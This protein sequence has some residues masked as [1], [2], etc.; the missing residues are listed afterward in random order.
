MAAEKGSVELIDKLWVWAKEGLPDPNFLKNKLLLS[1]DKHGLNA[2]Y[3]AAMTGS[4]QILGK[5]WDWVKELQLKPEGL[6]TEFLLSKIIREIPHGT[7][8]Y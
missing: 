6:K 2:W 4:V 5:L 1:R 3:I 7:R 8:H